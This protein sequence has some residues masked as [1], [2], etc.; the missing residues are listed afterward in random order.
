VEYG[1][2]WRF[3]CG[4]IFYILQSTFLKYSSIS[5]GRINFNDLKNVRKWREFR[6]SLIKC[7]GL[8]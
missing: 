1:W 5:T 4:E 7:K 6:R 8:G 2:G 3:S